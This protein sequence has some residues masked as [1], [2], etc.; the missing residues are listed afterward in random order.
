MNM[1]SKER[2]R[3]ILHTANQRLTRQRLLVLEVLEKTQQHLDAESLYRQAREYDPKISMATVYRTLALFKEAGLVQ[4]DRLGENHA[5]FEK[6]RE[7][8]HHHF[9]C[10]RC[11]RVIEF[12]A[13][14]V[15][16]IIARLS[17]DLGMV[18]TEASLSLIGYCDQCR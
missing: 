12:A 7:N 5:H 14:E 18:I 8:P 11:G 9:T 1:E 2:L 10:L 6:V 15:E 16:E 3:A 4:D 17:L 13:P